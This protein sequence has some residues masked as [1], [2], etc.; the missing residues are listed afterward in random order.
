MLR[1]RFDSATPKCSAR[2]YGE[3]I[4]SSAASG[5]RM[6]ACRGF[7]G[8]L[9][10]VAMMQPGGGAFEVALSQE[11]D[12]WGNSV[13]KLASSPG[14]AWTCS[15][16]AFAHPSLIFAR[17]AGRETHDYMRERLFDVI[18]AE[19][20]FWAVQGGAGKMG[21]HTNAHSGLH[22]SPRD[23]ARFG[24][25]LA[26]RE[27]WRGRQVVPEWWIDEATRTRGS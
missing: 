16:Q 3:R 27:K 18:G 5:S 23:F 7:S 4:S 13:A 9:P 15:N 20:N 1:S 19:S 2:P 6:T 24:Y 12:R 11:S 8:R 26:H 21:P 14:E 22:L 10:Q 25:L 17:A